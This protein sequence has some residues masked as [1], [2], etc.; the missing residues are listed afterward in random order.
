MQPAQPPTGTEAAIDVDA[1]APLDPRWARAAM[2]SPEL[3]AS[4]AATIPPASAAV[5]PAADDPDPTDGTETAAIA[6][7][8]TAL[9]RFERPRSDAGRPPMTR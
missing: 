8:E 9:A 2:P 4:V 7:D 5:D 1:L 3:A 6:P